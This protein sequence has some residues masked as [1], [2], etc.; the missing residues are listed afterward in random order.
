MQLAYLSSD[1]PGE[2]DRLLSEAAG[3]LQE[4]GVRLAGIVRD[5]REQPDDGACDST[6]RVLPDGPRVRITQDLGAGSSGCRLDPR[7]LAEA[8]SLVEAGA[9]QRAELFILNK[10]GPEEAGG[11]GFVELIGSALA[12]GVPV[13]VGVGRASLPAFEQFADGMAT[14]LPAELPALLAWA[15]PEA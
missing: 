15:T 13:L 11:K 8:V 6:V 1:Q 7:A 5:W 4:R 14:A 2:I 3:V 9:P 10:F 12:H